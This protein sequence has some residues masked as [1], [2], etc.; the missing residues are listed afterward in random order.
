MTQRRE[1]LAD[2]VLGCRGFM[3]AETLLLSVCFSSNVRTKVD[4]RL[5]MFLCELSVGTKKHIHKI[6]LCCLDEQIV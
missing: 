2:M 3:F 1:S 5:R 4:Q 6:C